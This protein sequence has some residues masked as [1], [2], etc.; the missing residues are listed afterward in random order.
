MDIKINET[1]YK[2]QKAL[3]IESDV[4]KIQFLPENGAKI[5]SL[6]YKPLE[7]ECFVQR[8]GD[9]FRK[10][11]YDGVYLKA[12][13]AGFDDMFPNI[14][15]YYYDKYPWKGTR[16]PDH[17]EVWFLPWD[18]E[19]QKEKLYFKV[20]G[21]RLPYILEKWVSMPHKNTLRIEYK[22]TNPTPFDMDFSWAGHVMLNTE[23]GAQIYLPDDLKNAYCTYAKSGFLANYGDEF[24]W[25]EAVAKDGSRATDDVL[26]YYFKNQLKEGWGAMRC[27]SDNSIVGISFPPSQVPYM[28]LLHNEG[29]SHDIW[30]IDD[31]CFY[32]EPC[33]SAFDRPDIARLHGMD[34]VL[35]AR[36]SY[37]WYLNISVTEGE[38]VR[39][40]TEDGIIMI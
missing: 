31:Y 13:G 30:G 16:L 20:N 29:G 25:P 34:S 19:V 35:K 9:Q 28:A 11:P 38:N 2:G 23:E 7:K 10:Q 21:I 18:V 12:D 32:F 39:K 26:K 33:T 6:F 4:L 3:T 15:E 22:A 5:S 27:P 36:S 17:G 40:V 1:E 8:E 14:D 37:S 24:S